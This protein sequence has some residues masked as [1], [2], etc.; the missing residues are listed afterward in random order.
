MYRCA[1]AGFRDGSS[2]GLPRFTALAR[3][4]ARGPSG[5]AETIQSIAQAMTGV[6]GCQYLVGGP[7]AARAGQWPVPAALNRL[8]SLGPMGGQDGGDQR[9]VLVLGHGPQVEQ[10]A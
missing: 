10:A 9:L 4:G 7:I 8:I 1:G 3:R 5:G 2:C 6:G